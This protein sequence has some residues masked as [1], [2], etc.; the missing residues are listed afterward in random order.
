M[1]RA[2][3]ISIAALSVL[4]V[5]ASAI[6][7]WSDAANGKYSGTVVAVDQTAGTIVV[8]GMGPLPIE[9]ASA[10]ASSGRRGTS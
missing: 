8:E 6:P 7:G 1:N 4:A 5:V 2:R 3:S 9:K 10:C